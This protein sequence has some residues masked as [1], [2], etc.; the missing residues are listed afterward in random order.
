MTFRRTSVTAAFLILMI[1]VFSRL[2]LT[3][4]QA[5][6]QIGNE[7]CPMCLPGSRVKTDCTKFSSTTCLPCLVGTYMNK[8][9]ARRQCLF[10]KTCDKASGLKIKSPCT[11]TSDAVC[12]PLEGFYC[13]DPSDNGCGAAQKHRSCEPGQY[14][15]QKGTASTDTVCSDCSDGSFSDGSF[16]SCRPHTQCET[17]N[18]QLL[19]PGTTS[20]DAECE[21]HSLNKTIKQQTIIIIWTPV[22]VLVLLFVISVPV[23]FYF[24]HKIKLLICPGTEGNQGIPTEVCLLLR[25]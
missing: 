14:I 3:C 16:P 11:T 12:E 19:K 8:L 20:T 4:H 15:S 25:V 5:E 9:T 6:Y 10:C 24:R 17:K 13:V 18:L 7:C 2:S 1:K 21:E 23:V 22:S